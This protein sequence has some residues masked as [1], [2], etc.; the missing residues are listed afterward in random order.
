[1]VQALKDT[2][3]AKY[4]VPI[5]IST[6]DVRDT[7]QIQALPEKLPDEFKEVDILV[8]NAGLAL[9]VA[10]VTEIDIQDMNTM[11]QT[12]VAGVAVFTRLFA[13]GMVTRNRGH[14]VN[15]SSVA[16]HEAYAGGGM[17]CATKFAVDALTTATRHDLIASS[18]VRVSAISPGAVQTEFSNVRF[19]GDDAKAAAVYQ[20][21]VP[22]NG[23][24]CADN[25][26]YAVTR[27][28]HVQVGEIIVWATLQASA[29]GIAR[30]L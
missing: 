8:N 2:L 9:G 19:G 23:A 30:V 20:G 16:G 26:L 17:Y 29:K 10:P 15:I 18:N 22:L 12:N 5:F 1:V 6:L 25:V 14:I 24:D 21:I 11:L 3:E 27:P 7:A 28:P 4:Q 13:P